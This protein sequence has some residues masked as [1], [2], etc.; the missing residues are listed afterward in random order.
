M[1]SRK[2]ILFY[3]EKYGYEA[4]L[5]LMYLI[6]PEGFLGTGTQYYILFDDIL[7]VVYDRDYDRY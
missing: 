6:G 5:E 4:A 3:A 1:W 7:S 2:A